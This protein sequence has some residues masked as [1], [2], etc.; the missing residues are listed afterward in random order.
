MPR[1]LDVGTPAKEK[2]LRMS[3][4]PALTLA[5]VLVEPLPF[6]A[7]SSLSP[8]WQEGIYSLSSLDD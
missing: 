2:G 8:E 5:V 6:D 1:C 4:T 3:T 7:L